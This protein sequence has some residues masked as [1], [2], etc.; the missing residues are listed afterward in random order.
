MQSLVGLTPVFMV[1][2][3]SQ[4]DISSCS[5]NY[6]AEPL[7]ASFLQSFFCRTFASK[8]TDQSIELCFTDLFRGWKINSLNHVLSFLSL[9]SLCLLVCLFVSFILCL[10]ARLFLPFFR[11]FFLFLC[12]SLSQS[13]FSALLLSFFL[14][15]FV[16]SFMSN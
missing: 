13:S 7:L 4:L 9:V 3:S 14:S 5:D 10:F 16:F 2:L 15:F 11:S 6:L 12:L 1:Q 8:E